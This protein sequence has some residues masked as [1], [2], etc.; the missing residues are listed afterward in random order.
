[1]I[2]RQIETLPAANRAGVHARQGVEN[3]HVLDGRSRAPVARRTRRG[4]RRPT[5]ARGLERLEIPYVRTTE[6][7]AERERGAE[8]NDPPRAPY[9][10]VRTESPPPPL[11]MF[12]AK[13]TSLPF[14]AVR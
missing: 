8:G 7:R 3:G 11:T 1:V 13:A 9:H 4:I 2:A 6:E 14:G 5:P 12:P 10:F